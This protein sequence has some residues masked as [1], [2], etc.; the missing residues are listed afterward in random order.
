MPELNIPLM[1]KVM[2]TI[3]DQP[4]LWDQSSW[5]NLM[6]RR[7]DNIPESMRHLY[8]DTFIANGVEWACKT[9]GCFAGHA[10]LL[11]GATF[12]FDRNFPG[13]LRH[14]DESEVIT[15]EGEKRAVDDYATEVLG[16]THS[17]SSYLFYGGNSLTDLRRLV[18]SYIKRA[19]EKL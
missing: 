11:S 7:K 16:L 15:P 17:Q 1:R 18:D 12:S 4:E 10:A 5:L 6:T 9:E 13:D 3:E 2:E 19:E 8:T 14:A